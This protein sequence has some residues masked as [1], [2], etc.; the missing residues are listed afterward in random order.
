[1]YGS[2]F[3]ARVPTV[4]R[5]TQFGGHVQ[6]SQQPER[7]EEEIKAEL[8]R[9]PQ[10]LARAPAFTGETLDHGLRNSGPNAGVDRTF[11][12]TLATVLGSQRPARPAQELHR[13]CTGRARIL[14]LDR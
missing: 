3:K 14:E 7:I 8:G 11:S 13:L 6:P 5:A 10:R 1:M 2:R 4:R 9:M 12:I